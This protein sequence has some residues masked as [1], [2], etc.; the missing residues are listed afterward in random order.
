MGAFEVTE[1]WQMLLYGTPWAGPVRSISRLGLAP[2]PGCIGIFCAV[3]RRSFPKPPATSGYLLA[4]LR[5]EGLHCPASRCPPQ[6][7]EEF[8]NFLCATAPEKSPW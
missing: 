6:G 4:T 2:Q 5:F 8:F 1:G 3:V 7:V